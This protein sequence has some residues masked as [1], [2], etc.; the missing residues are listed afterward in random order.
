MKPHPTNGDSQKKQNGYAHSSRKDSCEH[1][2]D[3][4][5]PSRRKK[6]N[7]W[8]LAQEPRCSEPCLCQT[9][10]TQRG[11]QVCG[12]AGRLQLHQTTKR[13][14]GNSRH[15]KKMYTNYARV[16]SLSTQ[17]NATCCHVRTGFGE[18]D[19]T[20]RLLDK[21]MTIAK[22]GLAMRSDQTCNQTPPVEFPS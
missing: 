22:D 14:P 6:N 3:L 10:E 20:L 13:V 15:S 18:K 16:P 5:F 1:D 7:C 17:S 12:P 11:T 21:P 2:G 8:A 9:I 19:T 4:I